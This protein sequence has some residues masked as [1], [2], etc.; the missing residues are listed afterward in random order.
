MT[1]RENPDDETWPAGDRRDD[2]PD[3]SADAALSAPA[4]YWAG[5]RSFVGRARELAALDDGLEAARAGAGNLVLLSG[6]P[7]I[8]KTRT[9]WEFAQRA[10][11]QDAVV[12][13]GRCFEGEWARPYGP[14]VTALTALVEGS[15]PAVLRGRLGHGTAP[16]A[17]LVPAIRAALPDVPA[18]APFSPTEERVRLH[19]A[20]TGLLLASART[21]PLVLVLDDLQWADRA[22]LGLLQCLGRF[23]GTAPLLAVGAC[24]DERVGGQHPLADTLAAL[25]REP[26]YRLLALRGLSELEVHDYL[27]AAV[28]AP[29]AAELARAVR[30]ETDGNPFFVGEVAQQLVD[31]HLLVRRD[32][33][34]T[35]AIGLAEMATPDGVRWV[36][37]RRVSGLSPL[38]R[39]V[40]GLA[41]GFGGRFE[42]RALRAL[43]R[44]ADDALAGCL[45]EA[46]AARLVREAGSGTDSYDFVH[47][48]LRHALYDDLNPSRRVR[49]HRRIAQALERVHGARALT[50]ARELAAQY[51]ASAAL[52][53]ATAGIPYA[54]AAAEQ[55]RASYA[56]GQ[57]VTFLRMAR[58]LAAEAEPVLQADIL[59]RLAIAE[60]EAG[61]PLE[62]ERTIEDAFAA[63]QAAGAET[64]AILD[65]L[66]AA[67]N[68]L[69]A[70]GVT[71]DAVQR[72]RARSL[73][74]AG[75]HHGLA[76]ARL[77]LT[78]RLVPPVEPLVGGVVVV[79]RWVES[80]PLAVA[81]AR[82]DGDELDYV[83]SLDLIYR[84]H[85]EVQALLARARTWQRPRATI[86]GLYHC[87]FQLLY[88]HGAFAEAAELCAEMA[89]LTERHGWLSRQASAL[90]WQARALVA[91]GRFD[92][93]GRAAV[94]A[95]TVVARSQDKRMRVLAPW[96]TAIAAFHLDGDWLELAPF[97]A[98]CAADPP[99]GSP[100]GPIAAALVATAWARA[101]NDVEARR[102]LDALTP[103][104]Q[105]MRPPDFLHNGTVGMAAAA[106]WEVGAVEYAPAYRALAGDLLAAGV[107]DYPMCSHDLTVGRMAALLGETVEAEAAFARARVSLDVSGQRPLR[108][109][110]DHDEALARIRWARR[111]LVSGRPADL[112]RAVRPVPP[113]APLNG[114]AAPAHDASPAGQR[115]SVTAL[116]DAAAAQFCTLGM[117]GWLARVDA[118]R[119][120]LP[121]TG[122]ESAAAR[123]GH[124]RLTRRE[125][126]VLGLVA[127]GET[128]KEI[129]AGLALS[130]GTV[131]RH[132]ANIYAKLGASGRAEAAVYAVH[133]GLVALPR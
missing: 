27:V 110:V 47:A 1:A 37:N 113:G 33:G 16:L 42:F 132:L 61:M 15:D 14:W 56:Y 12:L 45:D 26:G 109:I 69:L 75:D 125:I 114:A 4:T 90:L 52:P 3:R 20:V 104:A 38:A 111:G 112:A 81:I 49:L 40:L 127:A 133:H 89:G 78:A 66:A 2:T 76:W 51:H 55:A 29:V 17:Q 100:F 19:D 97:F 119:A 102:L 21:R 41:S 116:L 64:E 131:E 31:E 63:M 53:G 11:R 70:S 118:L 46:L 7:G 106:A 86:D 72:L 83:A 43:T 124:A 79:G 94:L 92:E 80:D 82:A 126:E 98:R 99:T 8:G 44:L 122:P 36:V 58:R 68:A 13:W 48:I 128:N 85:D 84:P 117:A 77:M 115:A 103:L 60:G 93:A 87:A 121:A 34:W 5:A 65:F 30:A 18:S 105:R 95:R 57:A 73:A 91:L 54:L 130:V 9:M 62:A 6:E 101:G 10:R 96:M 59:R 35:S 39:R 22:S 129:A 50:H 74:L 88:W 28:D 120:A 123:P 32:G 67:L 25:R 24:R 23:L 108:A 71:D 107:G